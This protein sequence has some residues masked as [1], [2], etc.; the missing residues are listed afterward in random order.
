VTANHKHRGVGRAAVWV[1]A[2]T[3]IAQFMSAL[4]ALVVST[5]LDTIK[6][7]LHAS[8]ADLEWTVNAYTLTFAVLL[9]SASALGDRFGRRRLFTVGLVLFVGASA[10]CAL[11]PSIGWLIGA[12]A[13]EGVGSALV[14][15]TGLTL[16]TTAFRPERRGWALGIFTSVIG[17][18]V[19]GGPVVGGAITQGLDWEWIF[20]LNVPIGLVLVVLAIR[21]IPESHGPPSRIDT[22]G[23]VLVT[24]AALGIV[25]GLVRGNTAGWGSAEVLGTIVG[26]T[27]LAI[28]FV[29]WELR[30]PAPMLPMRLF[31]S[32]AFAAGN[33][34]SFLLFASNFSTVF[35][36]AQFQQIALGQ[37]PLAA[38]VRLLPW[39]AP[40]FLISPR[41]GKLS[42][43]IGERPLV[44]G[45]LLLQAAGM[46][47]IALLA[48]PGL[49]YASLIAPMVISSTGIALA[50]PA[51]Q[52]AVVGS[53][54]A[55]DLGK[56]S[57]TYNT[58]RWFGAV[59]GVAILVAVFAGTGSYAS[60]GSFSHGFARAIA[61]SAGLAL[62]GAIVGATLPQ[63]AGT[64]RLSP[65]PAT[66]ALEP[67]RAG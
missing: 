22:T 20:W 21:Q 65:I 56:A 32:P 47:W 61:T 46:V 24:V 51:V 23:L 30:S 54:A 14:A 18:A 53:V 40:L 42:D 62:I 55:A 41:A 1:L 2:I 60:P 36:M 13:V 8:V 48:A 49:A 19:L 17:L 3:S 63:R 27:A 9:M 6:Q 31:T 59:F 16:L 44:T 66:P 29:A 28:S 57:G 37:G 26:G 4:D 35:F 33:A 67:D 58:A 52:K 7:H 15:P 11:A 34:T 25:W 10:A 45:G 43:R 12:R 38:G 50:M 64:A 5:A 39:T